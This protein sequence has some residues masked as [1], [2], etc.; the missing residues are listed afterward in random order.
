MMM[1]KTLAS[2]RRRG[3]ESSQ[4]SVFTETLIKEEISL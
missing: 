1:Q 2:R 3:F 4:R